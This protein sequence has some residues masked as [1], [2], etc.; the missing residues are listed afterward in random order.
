MMKTLFLTIV[1]LILV[2]SIFL[3]PSY[4]D[5]TTPLPWM[6]EGARLDYET[7]EAFVSIH[8]YFSNTSM[9]P[10]ALRNNPYTTMVGADGAAYI[11]I[12]REN[13]PISIGLSLVLLEKRGNMGL[14]NVTLRIDSYSSSKMLL[15]DLRE[16]DVFTLDGTPLGK[17][18]VWIP[19]CKGG[20]E[21]RFVG[22]GNSTVFAKISGPF[23]LI[24]ASSLAE[25]FNYLREPKRFQ[26]SLILDV[27]TAPEYRGIRF[28]EKISP[29]KRQSIEHFETRQSYYDADT[30]ILVRSSTING[31]AL[32][33]AFDILCINTG[34][35]L[36]YTNIDLGP[37]S[38]IALLYLLLTPALFIA[39]IIGIPIYIFRRKGKNLG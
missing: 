20:D 12:E 28:D 21:I 29:L 16:R 22:I 18:T 33:S 24:E 17:T 34:L 37:P 19:P 26:D 13:P 15:I 11:H 6:K 39:V 31:E 5:L 2:V 35:R 23:V 14:F 25:L 30:F 9:I 36:T 10:E 1:I 4:S 8:F 7:S 27:P 38:L 32:M 3:S